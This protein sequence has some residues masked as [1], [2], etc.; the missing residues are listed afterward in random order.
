MVAAYISEMMTDP[1]IWPDPMDF[2]PERW[3]HAYKGIE[4]DRKVFMP[5]SAGS[6]NC[7]GQQQVFLF[8]YR[9][10]ADCRRFAMKVRHFELSLVPG[11]SH[12]LRVFTTPQFVQG[13][14]NVGIKLRA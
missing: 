14:Y 9:R 5:F 11:Q 6:R 3:L 8:L 7:I 12:E 4:A 10:V 2:I 13:F 1:R